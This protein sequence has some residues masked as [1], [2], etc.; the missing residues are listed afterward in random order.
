VQDLVVDLVFANDEEA[1]VTAL[2]TFKPDLIF[3]DIFMPR[4]RMA[5]KLPVPSVIW[6]KGG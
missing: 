3:M 6:K 5:R 2:Q 1:V 4:R